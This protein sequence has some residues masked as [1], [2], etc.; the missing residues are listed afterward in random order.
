MPG[1]PPFAGTPLVPPSRPESDSSV[2]TD[3]A[4]AGE[5]EDPQPEQAGTSAAGG[6]SGRKRAPKAKIKARPAPRQRKSKRKASYPW[7]KR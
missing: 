5:R 4:L 2:A 6:E 1:M 3:G 7:I